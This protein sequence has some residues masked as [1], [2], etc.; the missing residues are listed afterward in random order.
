M[1]SP[2]MPRRP[3]DSTRYST[4][5]AGVAVAVKESIV[6]AIE[7]AVDSG[8]IVERVEVVAA[9]ATAVIEAEETVSVVGVVVADSVAI[10]DVVMG[11]NRQVAIDPAPF[12]QQVS[13]HHHLRDRSL[14]IYQYYPKARQDV[15]RRISS[16]MAVYA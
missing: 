7:A 13:S 14:C 15:K 8:V 9:E 12:C 1:L 16:I 2:P 3:T 10:V 6:G 4:I 5:V 11:P